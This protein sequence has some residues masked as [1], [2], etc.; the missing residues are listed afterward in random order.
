LTGGELLLAAHFRD[1]GELSVVE[2]LEDRRLLEQTEIHGPKLRR[3]GGT[4]K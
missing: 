1:A 4:G 2:V 3:T